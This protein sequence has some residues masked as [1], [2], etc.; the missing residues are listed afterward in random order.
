MTNRR[1][2][3]RIALAGSAMALA[4][5]CWQPALLL[6]AVAAVVA[7]AD[8]RRGRSVALLAAG[9]LLPNL[10]YESYFWVHGVLG[11]QIQQSYV[12]PGN[13]F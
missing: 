10:V 13:T 5:L 4:F 8:Q 7:L 9:L 2:F 1:A 11:E 12:F 3:V 6:A